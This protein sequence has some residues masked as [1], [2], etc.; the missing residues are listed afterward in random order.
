MGFVIFALVSLNKGLP[1]QSVKMF[2]LY[3]TKEPKNVNA[4]R[5]RAKAYRQLG[6]TAEAEA[7]EKKAKIL[8]NNEL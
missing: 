5:L 1:D 8:Q 3:L 6:K 2:S 4:Y 7:N